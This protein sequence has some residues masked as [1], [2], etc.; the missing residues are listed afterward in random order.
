MSNVIRVLIGISFLGVV[1][2]GGWWAFLRPI[3]TPDYLDTEGWRRFSQRTDRKW[4]ISLWL[5]VL[6]TAC[7]A[8]AGIVKLL[9]W[10]DQ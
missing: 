6:S 5:G 10:A 2:F 1:L 9:G 7:F 4:R 8:L 3:K